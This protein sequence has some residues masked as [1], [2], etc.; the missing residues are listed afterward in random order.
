MANT[1]KGMLEGVR[2][3]D[4]S[5][6]LAGPTATRMMAE[7]GAE[8][9]KVELTPH[10]DAIR[11]FPILKNGQSGY[12]IQQNRG[13]KSLCINPKDPR[14]RAVIEALVP[15][16]DVFLE[17]FSVGAIGR[18][19]FG[20]EAVK[21]LNPSIIMA[22]VSAF[23]QEGPLAHL[24]GFDYIAAAY[25]GVL[26]MIG[27]PDGPP[28]F[29]MLA[30]GDVATGVHALAAINAALFHRARTGKGTFIDVSLLDSY[31]HMHEVNV[32]GYSGSGGT[33]VPKWAGAHH[34]ASAPLGNFKG[35][36]G[37]VMI[38]ALTPA[39]WANVARVIGREELAS[40]PAYQ[41]MDGR[42]ERR[43]EIN[44]L[45]QDWMDREPDDETILRKLM[46]ARIP[47]APV[48][49]VPQAMDHPHLKER[50]TVRRIEDRAFGPL[51]IPGDPLRFSVYP[52]RL[53]LDAPFL[54]EHN[55]EILQEVLG[56]AEDAVAALEKDGVL[57]SDA[58]QRGAASPSA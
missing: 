5:H 54:G 9:I 31:F 50:G 8:I 4:F 20:Y 6:M 55:R 37:Y 15:Q 2:V 43:E 13:K 1:G 34:Y 35:K 48:L 44:A 51:D 7:M 57:V 40:D 58:G 46:E 16:C 36:S 47:C 21:A 45:V 23:G 27:E 28:L 26:D 12:F 3:L 33:F 42:R 14:G 11:A 52:E 32:Q 53:P 49:S 18:M 17:N 39:Q 41:T 22:S 19:G 24:P 38:I 10:G 25:A 29:P 56:M 30:V